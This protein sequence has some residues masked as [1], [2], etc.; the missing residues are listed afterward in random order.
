MARL[1][2]LGGTI[3]DRLIADAVQ[4]ASQIVGERFHGK[5]GYQIVATALA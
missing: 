3:D 2:L 4:T 1:P 5:R